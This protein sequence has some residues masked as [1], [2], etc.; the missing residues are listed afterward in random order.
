MDH[1]YR[2][3]DGTST[4]FTLLV[5]WLVEFNMHLCVHVRVF[6]RVSVLSHAFADARTCRSALVSCI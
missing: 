5:G 6:V 1:L 2:W 3:A 4:L